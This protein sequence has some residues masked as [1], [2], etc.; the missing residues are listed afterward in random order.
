MAAGLLRLGRAL[1]TIR[2]LAKPAVKATKAV[3]SKA[4]PAA[5][6]VASGAKTLVTPG[7]VLGTVL[8]GGRLLAPSLAKTALVGGGLYTA[9]LKGAQ[10]LGLVTPDSF[11]DG[12]SVDL[13]T[14]K[15]NAGTGVELRDYNLFD[16]LNSAILGLG[17]TDKDGKNPY[18]EQ[19]L[20]EKAAQRQRTAIQSGDEAVTS[21]TLIQKRGQ[22]ISDMTGQT[23]ESSLAGEDGESSFMKMREGENQVKYEQRL[24]LEKERLA[25]LVELANLPDGQGL[26]A[27]KGMDVN[28]GTD[29][30][31][32]KIQGVTDKDE[33][34]P[35]NVTRREEERLRQDR[36]L[37]AERYRDEQSLLLQKLIADSN[38]SQGQLA[39]QMA[40][41]QYQNRALDM[42]EA[43]DARKDKQLM[44][45]QLMKGLSE[46][47]KSM[48]Y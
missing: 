4:A 21:G 45:M 18:S 22:T 38:N 15:P 37:Q 44:I 24:A 27:L 35:R 36:A 25:K 43:R 41:Q 31:Q 48:A 12:E 32:Q 39:L 26:E 29:E 8:K 2:G 28:A 13:L 20:A 23:V 5:K 17:V 34:N 1:N 47:G 11:A 7:P 40:Q 33:F 19:S 9:G 30:I 6:S 46:M 14:Y 3:A 10:G 42:R 16:R